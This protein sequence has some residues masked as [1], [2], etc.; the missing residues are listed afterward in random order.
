MKAI[1][2]ALFWLTCLFV[3]YF[4]LLNKHS[5]DITAQVIKQKTEQTQKPTAGTK[6]QEK[7]KDE[8]A[9]TYKGKTVFKGP[10]GG[11]YYT[12]DKGK[13]IYIKKEQLNK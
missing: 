11:L 4:A 6:P 5:N 7:K 13:K 10:K 8:Q 2:K 3:L 9:G 12:N 1:L